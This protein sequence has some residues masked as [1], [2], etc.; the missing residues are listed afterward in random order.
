MTSVTFRR[1]LEAEVAQD[2]LRIGFP[3]LAELDPTSFFIHRFAAA[4]IFFQPRT[5]GAM[6]SILFGVYLCFSNLGGFFL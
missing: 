2:G 6:N 1:I 4:I 5:P 3:N